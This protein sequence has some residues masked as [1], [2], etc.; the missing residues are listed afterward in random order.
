VIDAALDLAIG[1][2]FVWAVINTGANTFTVTA[3]TGHTIVGTATVVTAV[4]AQFRTR[5][6]AADTFVSYRLAG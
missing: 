4:S 3:S 1:D 6:T 2:S 5:K